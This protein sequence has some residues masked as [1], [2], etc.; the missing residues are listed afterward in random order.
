MVGKDAGRD[1]LQIVAT[2]LPGL[3]FDLFGQRDRRW[4]YIA[5]NYCPVEAISPTNQG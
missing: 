3:S 1:S 2:T 5:Q 4:S